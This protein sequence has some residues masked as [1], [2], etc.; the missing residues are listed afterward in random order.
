[1]EAARGVS[2]GVAAALVD[3]AGRFVQENSQGFTTRRICWQK[4]IAAFFEKG[5]VQ[6]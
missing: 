6:R 2:A 4:N 1:M 5:G 3:Q